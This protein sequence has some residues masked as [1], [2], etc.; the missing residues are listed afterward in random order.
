MQ[1]ALSPYCL[2]N[3]ISRS[4]TQMETGKRSLVKALIWN[5]IGLASM[6][7]VGFLATGSAS[8]GGAM[9]LIN[10]A[11]GF[12]SYLIYERVWTRINWGRHSAVARPIAG[13]GGA[14]ANV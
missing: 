3:R 1:S 2:F 4:T 6:A 14:R 11:L 10:S 9:A 13:P 8:L 5:A 7:L 12:G